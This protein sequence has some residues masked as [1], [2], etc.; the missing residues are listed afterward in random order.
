MKSINWL[1]V[2]SIYGIGIVCGSLYG[3]ATFTKQY[4]PKQIV[5]K[6]PDLTPIVRLL[7]VLLFFLYIGTSEKLNRRS[8]QTTNIYKTVTIKKIMYNNSFNLYEVPL[9]LLPHFLD[10]RIGAVY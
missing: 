10:K 9:L 3:I 4:I 7:F 5:S 6:I 8:P 1:F 2:E